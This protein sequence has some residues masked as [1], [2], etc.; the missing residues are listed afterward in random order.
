GKDC[1]FIMGG[2]ILPC[3]SVN[4]YTIRCDYS[5][6]CSLAIMQ[7][8]FHDEPGKISV[9]LSEVARSIPAEGL[10]L[11]QLLGK[12]GEQGLLVFCIFLT[13]PFL[14]PIQIPGLSTVFGLLIALV[15]VGVTANRVP[16]LP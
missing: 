16:S 6:D 15:A 4:T 3:R 13:I 10:T 14:L 9:T 5:G 11:Y 8:P 7:T 2:R 1:P 12:L